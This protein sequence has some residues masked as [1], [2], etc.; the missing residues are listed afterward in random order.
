MWVT[1]SK[2]LKSSNKKRNEKYD[3]MAVHSTRKT[4]SVL[5]L[6]AADAWTGYPAKRKLSTIAPLRLLKP[7]NNST[8][9]FVISPSIPER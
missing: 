9:L 7:I 6:P 5:R 8:N 4:I 1:R 3:H 2:S